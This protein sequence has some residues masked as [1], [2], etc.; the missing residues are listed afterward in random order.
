MKIVL[1]GFMATGKSTVAPLVAAKL[2]LE[3]VEM[4]DLT[5]KKSGRHSIT[6]IFENDG[7]AAFRDLETAVAKDL[8]HRDNAVISTGGG[9]VMNQA[10]IDYLATD[11]LVVELAAPF[12]TILERIGPDIPRPLFEDAAK[13]KALYERREP[14]YSKY[15][16]IHIS[17][18]DK[19]I[20]Q[21]VAEIVKQVQNL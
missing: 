6:E 2:G 9:V 3:V 21:V 16:T 13:A 15:A 18:D 5:I 12:N 11:A 7:E 20:D 4:D 1:I 8:Q 10:I 14:L 19:S 17:T